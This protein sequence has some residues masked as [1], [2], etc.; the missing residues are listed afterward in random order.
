MPGFRT[1]T[2]NGIDM[3][4]DV[5]IFYTKLNAHEIMKF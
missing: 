1:A 3:F 5:G 2:V 4:T